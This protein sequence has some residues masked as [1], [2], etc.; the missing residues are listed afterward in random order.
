MG[1]L[2]DWLIQRVRHFQPL[3]DDSP[4]PGVISDGLSG[5]VVGLNH[6]S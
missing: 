3:A 5:Y 2:P 6:H 4:D 1:V